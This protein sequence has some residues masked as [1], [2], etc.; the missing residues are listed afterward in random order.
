MTSTRVSV[1]FFALAVS[2]LVLSTAGRAQSPDALTGQ[3][4]LLF[5]QRCAECHVGKGNLTKDGK[6]GRDPVLGSATSRLALIQGGYIVSGD[7]AKSDLLSLVTL[8]ADDAD[9]M[10]KDPAKPLAPGEVDLLRRWIAGDA[11]GAVARS[12]V[13]ERAVLAA[14][15]TDLRAL[16]AGERGGVRYLSLHHLWN[17][18]D[19]TEPDTNFDLY[20]AAVSKLLN[21][22]SWQPRIAVPEAVGKDK[23]L[24]RIRL[25]DYG[26]SAATWHYFAERYPYGFVE[27]ELDRQIASASGTS[28]ALVLRAD[29]LV[30]AGAQSPFYE[31]TLFGTVVP[32]IRGDNAEDALERY[33]GVDVRANL[34]QALTAGSVS[35]RERLLGGAA[36]SE[37]GLPVLRAGFK[38]SGVSLA[39]RLIERHALADGRAYWKSYDFSLAKHDSEGDLFQNPLGPRGAGLSESRAF[40]HDGGEIIFHLPN[41]LQGYLL[42]TAAGKFLPR[43]PKDIV[44]DAN[45][46]DGI[47]LNG[48][49]CMKCHE[50]GMRRP[51]D[52]KE[53]PVRDD[54]RPGV[55]ANL[56]TFTKEERRVLQNLHADEPRLNAALKADS[57]RFMTAL[58][59]AKAAGFGV[60]PVGFFYDRF[61]RDI[62]AEALLTE[63]DIDPRAIRFP[64][65]TVM[66]ESSHDIVRSKA[67]QLGRGFRRAE[68]IPLF[69][70][71]A[72]ELSEVPMRPFTPVVYEEF[73]GLASGGTVGTGGSIPPPR[74]DA[75]RARPPGSGD[76]TVAL[77]GGVSMVLKAIAVGTFTMGSPAAEE[78][79]EGDE[80]PQTRVTNTKPFWLGQTEV[81]QAQWQ[82][83]MINNPSTFAG[84][85]RPVEKVSWEEA[86]EFCAKLTTQE[87]AA[88]RLPAGHRYTLPT[89]AQ[90]EYACRAGTSG[91]FAGNLD[92]M[93]WYRSNS[94]NETQPVRQKQANAWGLHD[95]HGNVWEWC[96]DYFGG[97]LPG[98][99]LSDPTGPASGSLRVLR[100]GGWDSSAADCRSAIRTGFPPGSRLF[101]LGFRLALSSVP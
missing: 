18:G 56:A 81:T 20:R 53:G 67:T 31:E 99:S 98:G 42:T 17:L 83:V 69:Q 85:E 11:T 96:A 26:W 71:L 24:L 92:S 12:F 40:E 72:G 19:K 27:A 68:F 57:A 22:L 60:E 29:W 88:G 9:R 58:G 25:A 101:N 65:A 66:A 7:P 23:L 33:L 70:A 37:A 63:L 97:S 28:A 62:T 78:G 51:P 41:G 30:F 13:A 49:S 48:V 32:G 91:P 35:L 16:P 73:S 61:L 5:E 76:R 54:I 100:G 47:I 50:S 86:M 36:S 3:V 45:R 39:N 14:V 84:A 90:W 1:P 93:G 6:K 21:S 52:A 80:G 87:Q 43:A 10:P 44:Q 95:M 15:L 64:L 82:A 2:C 38:N 59:A 89:E 8:P 77:G 4:K 34:R 79:R 94:G 55:Q 74:S 75:S 46:R